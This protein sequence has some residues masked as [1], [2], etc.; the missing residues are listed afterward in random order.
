MPHIILTIKAMF[1]FGLLVKG[2]H[3]YHKTKPNTLNIQC[4]L[5]AYCILV[6]CFFLYELLFQTVM[7]LYYTMLF[8]SFCQFMSLC[9]SLN[10]VKQYQ[11][12]SNI[13]IAILGILFINYIVLFI[14]GPIPRIG[15]FCTT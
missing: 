7:F 8:A 11:T 9:V 14:I 15:S 3:L 10:M 2:L 4:L 6:I 5:I 1:L 12:K 13:R